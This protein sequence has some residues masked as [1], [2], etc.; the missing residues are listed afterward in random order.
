[1][2]YGAGEAPAEDEVGLGAPIAAVIAARGPFIVVSGLCV[3]GLLIGG[4]KFMGGCAGSVGWCIC[5]CAVSI[6][7]YLDAIRSGDNEIAV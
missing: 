5:C 1:M 4:A 3:R 2:E 7:V 6:G